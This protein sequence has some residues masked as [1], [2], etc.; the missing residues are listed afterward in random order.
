MY[1]GLNITLG[2]SEKRIFEHEGRRM[3]DVD[4]EASS[5]TYDLIS[6]ELQMFK[7]LF[8]CNNSNKVRDTLMDADEENIMS[9]KMT[10]KLYKML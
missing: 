10:L 2:A 3:I 8:K 7:K 4:H 1:N 5:D 6:K 9:L